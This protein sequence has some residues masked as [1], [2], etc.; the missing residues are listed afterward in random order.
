MRTVR[1]SAPAGLLILLTALAAP[2]SVRADSATARA[3]TAL[4][5]RRLDLRSV[6]TFDPSSGRT[7]PYQPSSAPLRV[8]HL[9]A[10]ECAPC[11]AEMPMLRNLINGW[12]NEPGVQFLLISETLDQEKLRQF[13]QRAA[14]KVPQVPALYQSTDD[15]LRDGLQTGAQPLTLLVDSDWVIRQAFVGSLLE[16]TAEFAASTARL[17]AAVQHRK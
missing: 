4:L 10:V 16:R 15:R 5:H 1:Q 3:E 6:R 8:I 12:R 9:W 13:W 7:S 14:D 11:I 2:L 17:L